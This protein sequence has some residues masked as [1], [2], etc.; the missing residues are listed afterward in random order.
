MIGFSPAVATPATAMEKPTPTDPNIIAMLGEANIADSAVGALAAAKGT[1]PAVRM[2]GRRTM[3]DQ[4]A[5]HASLDRVV[6]ANGLTSAMPVGDMSEAMSK[7]WRDTLQAMPGGARWDRAYVDHEVAR[8][9]RILQATE[10]ASTFA[11]N[12]DLKSLLR[13]AATSMR[14]H[15]ARAMSLQSKMGGT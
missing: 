1:E 11:H 10:S 12:P 2:F 9:Q 8:L 13:A 4:H 15:L 6:A 14:A 5:L 7:A 3:L